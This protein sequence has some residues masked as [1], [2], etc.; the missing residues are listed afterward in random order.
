MSGVI[1]GVGQGLAKLGGE[2][3][4]KLADEGQ[5]VLESTISGKELLGLDGTMTEKE[6][7]EAGKKDEFHKKNQVNEIKSEMP[8]NNQ[9]KEQLEKGRNL[10]GEIKKV[11]EEKKNKEEEEERIFLENIKKQREEE[12]EE[13]ERT[14][15][16]MM[17]SSNPAKQEKS[18][19]SAFAKKKKTGVDQAQMSQTS[20]FKGK[21]N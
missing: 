20:E 12:K 15:G 2:T 5:K 21:L 17:K 6:L 19:G 9:N 10:E 11:R 7:V 3:V 1:K 4:E 8:E 16:V 14:M 18:R 13:E